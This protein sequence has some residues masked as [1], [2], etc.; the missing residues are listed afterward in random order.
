MLSSVPRQSS[1]TLVSPDFSF[2]PWKRPIPSFPNV[3]AVVLLFRGAADFQPSND[4]LLSLRLHE[5]VAVTAEE[6]ASATNLLP[7]RLEN[8]SRLALPAGDRGRRRQSSPGCVLFPAWGVPGTEGSAS[9]AVLPLLTQIITRLKTTGWST[10]T[11]V[12]GKV[13]CRGGRHKAPE[14]H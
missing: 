9:G 10:G 5:V 4:A 6:V 7:P 13:V 8:S 3:F 1:C 12:P 2:I 11:E 14:E